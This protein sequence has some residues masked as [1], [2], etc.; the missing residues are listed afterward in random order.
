MARTTPSTSNPSTPTTPSADYADNF[1]VLARIVGPEL[2]QRYP[3]LESYDICQEPPAAEQDDPYPPPATQIDLDRAQVESLDWDT[4]TV[5]DLFALQD[6]GA[7]VRVT[8]EIQA[9]LDSRE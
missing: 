3:D 5:A 1:L 4:A 6:V 2:M 9:E 8:P 7:T